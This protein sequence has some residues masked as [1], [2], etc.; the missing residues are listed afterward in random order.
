[1]NEIKM[2]IIIVVVKIIKI[3]IV[4]TAAYKS[5]TFTVVFPKTIAACKQGLLHTCFLYTDHKICLEKE[6]VSLGRD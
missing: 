1:M 3:I 2:V 5:R 6:Y 4:I